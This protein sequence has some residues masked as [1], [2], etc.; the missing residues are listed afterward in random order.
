MSTAIKGRDG[1][2]NGSGVVDAESHVVLR[3]GPPV[4][5][6]PLT[7]SPIRAPSSPVPN[8]A[9]SPH[10]PRSPSALPTLR[11]RL[12]HALAILHR[13]I[14][15]PDYEGYVAHVSRCH[16][17]QTLLSRDEFVRQRLEDRYSRPGSRC[18]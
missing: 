13:I 16:P 6:S 12:R 7:I 2:A 15:A 11:D 1:R 17:E 3:G 8:S 14:G 18:C 9:R 5:A 4:P 10:P